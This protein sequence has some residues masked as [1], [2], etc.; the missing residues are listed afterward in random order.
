MRVL[1]IDDNVEICKL[2]E[3]AFASSGHEFTYALDGRE[4]LRLMRENVYDVV[5]LDIAMP[6]FSGLDLLESLRNENLEGKQKIVIVSASTSIENDLGQL[7][8]DAVVGFLRKP[9]DLEDLLT[10]AESAAAC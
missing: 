6:E 8:S 7:K 5:L 3:V 2:F 9:V 4:G 1:S 10:K